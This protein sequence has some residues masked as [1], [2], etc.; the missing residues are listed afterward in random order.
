MEAMNDLRSDMAQIHHE[1]N[2]LRKLVENCMEWQ[3]NL[4]HSIKQE[5]S[6]AVRQSCKCLHWKKNCNHDV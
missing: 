1:I 4:Q 2:E 3:A 6:E 5:V